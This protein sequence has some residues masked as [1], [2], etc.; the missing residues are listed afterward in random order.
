MGSQKAHLGGIS[1]P[2]SA[3]PV[4]LAQHTLEQ[5]GDGGKNGHYLWVQHDGLASPRPIWIMPLLYA[6]LTIHR[7][8]VEY[9]IYHHSEGFL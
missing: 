2:C 1:Q 4:G 9:P 6:Q 5:W 7:D 3:V 8:N